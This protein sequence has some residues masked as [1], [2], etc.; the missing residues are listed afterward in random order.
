VKIPWYWLL[1]LALIL[2]GAILLNGIQCSLWYLVFGGFPPPLLWLIVL[3]Y[4][5]VTRSLWEVT[6][7]T[8]LLTI[9]NAAFTAFPFEAMLVYSL[10]LMFI[11][12]LI[13]E[14]V[15]WGGPTFFMLMVGVASLTA[16]ILYWLASRWFDKNPVFIPQI[17]DWLISGLLTMLFSLPIYAVFKWFD[18]VA[19]QDAGAEGH[20]GPR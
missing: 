13:R 2:M 19:A 14:R 4:M 20:I 7:M 18:L 8:Y 15:F 5:S 6:L 11:I 3:V 9:V 12:I 16:P 10:A 1:S 17:F